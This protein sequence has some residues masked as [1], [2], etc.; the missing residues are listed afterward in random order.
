MILTT[1]NSVY[2]IDEDNFT[3]SRAQNNGDHNPIAPLRTE[4]GTYTK[5]VG[6]PVIGERFSLI[7]PPFKAGSTFRLITTSPVVSIRRTNE[8]S[9]K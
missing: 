8:G 2:V 6:K 5:L 9:I 1:E 7:C 3:W 4:S